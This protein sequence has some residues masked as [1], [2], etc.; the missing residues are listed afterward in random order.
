MAVR[1]GPALG[2][3][4]SYSSWHSAHYMRIIYIKAAISVASYS[5]VVGYVISLAI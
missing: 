1:A 3:Q 4:P 2:A 5:I